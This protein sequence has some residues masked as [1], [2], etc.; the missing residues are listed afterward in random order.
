MKTKLGLLQARVRCA[1][2]LGRAA[3]ERSAGSPVRSNL[4]SRDS[5]ERLRTVE[6]SGIAADCKVRAPLPALGRVSI[7]GQVVRFSWRGP[8]EEYS[9]SMDGMR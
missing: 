5:Y 2:A 1:V 4:G 9:V 8:V 7:E 3:N 6:R